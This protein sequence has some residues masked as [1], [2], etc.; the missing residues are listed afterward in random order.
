MNSSHIR[1]FVRLLEN[2]DESEV[3]EQ[4]IYTA[5]TAS[6]GGTGRCGKGF[7]MTGWDAPGFGTSHRAYL[8]MLTVCFQEGI[9]GF[10]R[11]LQGSC[12]ITTF[13]TCNNGRANDVAGFTDA[14]H[15]GPIMAHAA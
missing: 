4:P 6:F 15:Q 14:D 9:E 5:K 3:M 8:E 1:L 10:V 7:M 13:D 12:Y 11:F 2:G